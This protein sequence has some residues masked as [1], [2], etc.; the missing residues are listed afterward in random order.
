MNEEIDVSII[1]NEQ[2]LWQGIKENAIK[3]KM[4]AK[5]DIKMHDKVIELAE[6]EIKKE[7]QKATENQKI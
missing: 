5:A 2:K 4:N 3:A 6:E 7:E 1:S